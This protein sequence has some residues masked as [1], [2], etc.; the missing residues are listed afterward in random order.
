MACAGLL[1]TMAPA[2]TMPPMTMQT[3]NAPM[4]HDHGQHHMHRHGPI[5]L[6]G[7]HQLPEGRIVLSYRMGAMSMS[8]IRQ[9][10][11]DLS[12]A[13]LVTTEPN[14]FAG[15]PGQPPTIRL[16]P[17]EMTGQMHMLGAMYGLSDRLTLMGML[18][19]VEKSM[20][21]RTYAGPAGTTILGESTSK[22]KGLGDVRLGAL[23]SLRDQGRSRAALGLGLSL[24]TGSISETGQMLSPMG[25][26]PTMRLAY[27]M[28][29]GSGTYDLHPS[30]SYETGRGAVNW[31]G[32][33]R[34]II[35]LD[36]NDAG[37]RHGD[38]AAV[39]GWISYRAAPWISYAWRAE[40]RHADHIHGRDA[41]IMGPS[42]G[43][44]PRNYG[45]DYVTLYAGVDLT[46]KNG[47]L[48]GQL[49]GLELGLPVYQDLNG[50]QSKTDWAIAMA[51]RKPF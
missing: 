10:T 37:Y 6:P 16:A 7:R 41:L 31:G 3:D 4:V 17:V 13:T 19:Y 34:G 8:G 38:E 12:A 45:G 50:T 11:S 51:W 27:S 9:G 32:Q 44:D 49:I 36:E 26:L 28:Q 43:A 29:L 33:L 39:S 40:Y 47:L 22:T 42:L 48:K 30:L 21:M 46:P 14:A 25:T 24:P 35:R 2:Q 15:M 20:T 5:G 23:W 1:A 18:P